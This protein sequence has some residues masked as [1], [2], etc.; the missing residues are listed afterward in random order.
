MIYFTPLTQ[1]LIDYLDQWFLPAKTGL[2]ATQL[3]KSLNAF[4]IEFCVLPKHQN[5]FLDKSADRSVGVVYAART[6]L[7]IQP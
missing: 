7:F 3:F 4:W 5:N 6:Q 1:A 2:F